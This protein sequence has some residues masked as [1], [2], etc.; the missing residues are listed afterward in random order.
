MGGR[1]GVN[2]FYKSVENRKACCHLRKVEP[3]SRLLAGARLDHGFARINPPRAPT[4]HTP[5]S[6]PR[7]SC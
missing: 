3:L 5:S 2:G 4:S 1:T 7:I 6:T